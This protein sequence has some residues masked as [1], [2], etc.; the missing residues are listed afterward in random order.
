MLLSPVTIAP[1]IFTASLPSTSTPDMSRAPTALT[2]ST[3]QNSVVF[4][5]GVNST[6]EAQR[7]YEDTYCA[8]GDMEM[9]VESKEVASLE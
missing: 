1:A 7:I 3:N 5:P 9:T 8:R 2:S 6:K 4:T